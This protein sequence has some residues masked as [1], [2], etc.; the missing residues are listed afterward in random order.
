VQSPTEPHIIPRRYPY[1]KRS[2]SECCRNVACFCL[3]VP[4]FCLNV[5]FFCESVHFYFF[6]LLLFE[7]GA[8]GCAIQ[9]ASNVSLG[10][11]VS[12]RSRRNLTSSL[13]NPNSNSDGEDPRPFNLRLDESTPAWCD[14]TYLCLSSGCTLAIPA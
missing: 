2:L 7:R 4:C 8:I 10:R 12:S 5:P 6:Y 13:T 14:R 9:C 1:R 3:N 11:S